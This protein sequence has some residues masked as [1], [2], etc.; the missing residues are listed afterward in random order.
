MILSCLKLGLALD[1]FT[2]GLP[3]SFAK[4]LSQ[5][6]RV[7]LLPGDQQLA[8]A[9]STGEGCI[10]LTRVQA[11]HLSIETEHGFGC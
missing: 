5:Q 7:T 8:T 4:F 6:F 11:E 2:R 3:L 9:Y 1:S 10:D